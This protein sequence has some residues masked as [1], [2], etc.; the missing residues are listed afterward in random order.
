ML[1]RFD[2]FLIRIC[3]MNVFRINSKR[4]YLILVWK[5]KG[6]FGAG[7]TDQLYIFD[8]EAIRGLIF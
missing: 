1:F 5:I 4:I 7:D 8:P 2:F 3:R 6:F